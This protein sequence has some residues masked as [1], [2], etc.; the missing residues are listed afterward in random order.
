MGTHDGRLK[1]P[2]P[3][4]FPRHVTTL[5]VL[6]AAATTVLLLRN[7]FACQIPQPV[8]APGRASRAEALTAPPRAWAGAEHLIMV[9]GHAVY[10]APSHTPEDV[11]REA[12]WFL[13][14]FQHGQLATMLAHIRRGVELAAVDNSSLLIFSGGETRQAA[15]PQSEA[16]SYWEAAEALGWFGAHHVRDRSL[17]EVHARDSFENLAFALCRFREASGRYPERV[18]VVS[19]GFKR[20]RFVELHRSALRLPRSRFRYVGIDPPNLPTEVLRAELAKSSKPFEADP[21]GCAQPALQAKRVGRNPFR[22]HAGHAQGCPEM[23][24]LLEH[25]KTTRY[26]DPLPWSTQLG[27]D[28]DQGGAGFR[29]GAGAHDDGG[30]GAPSTDMTLMRGLARDL[31]VTPGLD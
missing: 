19:F 10:T 26:T 6:V 13:E 17:L 30:G 23:A 1:Y 20:R 2:P 12:S 4:K 29:S 25:C 7:S 27:D 16:R 18:S 21:Y 3:R 22:R 5:A 31:T 8:V 9:A 24:P 15:G 11:Q 14:P 28:D